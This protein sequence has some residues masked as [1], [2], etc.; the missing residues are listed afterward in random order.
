MK[1]RRDIEIEE[2]LTLFYRGETTIEQERLLK[3]FFKQKNIPEA[4]KEEQLVFNVIFEKDELEV[5]SHLEQRLLAT[6]D[7][8][9]RPKQK[10]AIRFIPKK[11]TPILIA[12]SLALLIGLTFFFKFSSSEQ[13]LPHLSQADREAVQKAQEA[14]ILVSTKY[15]EGIEQLTYSRQTVKYTYRIVEESLHHLNK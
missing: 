11:A 7:T 2:L 6:I 13:Q 4:L 1:T 10:K 3:D 12:A 15:N 14:L 9:A 5:P 8:L